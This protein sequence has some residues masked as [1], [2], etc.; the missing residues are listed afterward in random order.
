MTMDKSKSKTL[1]NFSLAQGGPLYHFYLWSGLAKKPLLLYKR[2][3]II[4]CLFAWLPLLI[5][6]MLNGLAFNGVKVPFIYDIDV[7]VRF[8]LSLALL[9]YAEFIADE[10]L[11]D[12]VQE[13][14]NCNIISSENKK[15]FQ[16]IVA[17]ANRLTNSVV[18]EIVFLVFV[19][20]VGNWISKE[21]FPINVATWYASSINGTVK[22]TPPGY[23]YAFVSLPFFQFLVLRWYYRMF[24]WYRFL[25]QVSR[26]PLKL[27]SLHPDRAGGLG[28]LASSVYAFEPLLLAH[29]V[30]LAGL[31][32]NRIWN[33]GATLSQF[34]SEIII[35][36]IFL[37]ILPL[38]PLVFFIFSL[39]KAKRTGLLAYNVVVQRYVDNFREKWINPESKN[40]ET[41]LGSTD[42]Q[43]LA[44][45]GNSFITSSQMRVIPFSRRS[46]ISILLLTIFPLVPLIFTIM[47]LEKIISQFVG[48]IF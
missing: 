23:W 38:A 19:I 3:M 42:I 28:F 41:L 43:S 18:V 40:T 47:P 39:A 25:W 27:N 5:L 32:F 13:F 21:Y 17:S 11:Q 31:I 16:A 36:M 2:R 33:A 29:S 14:L 26:L 48:I 15:K 45:L 7:H 22:L 8:L 4:V 35:I 30:L 1:I 24:I 44:D 46:I 9:I 10:R 20:I 6:T 34:Q 12:I 37:M